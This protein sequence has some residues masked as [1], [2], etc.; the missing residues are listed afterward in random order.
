MFSI[1]IS[2][3][4]G[5]DARISRQSLIKPL[6]KAMGHFIRS[7]RDCH[8]M[9]KK[10]LMYQDISVNLISDTIKALEMAVLEVM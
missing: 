2:L 3:C 8:S 7:T 9:S 6:E 5:A 10:V 1:H 4:I